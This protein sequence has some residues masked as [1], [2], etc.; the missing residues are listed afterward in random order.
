MADVML[1]SR[2]HQIW[3]L[4]T[5]TLCPVVHDAFRIRVLPWADLYGFD[6]RSAYQ[7]R[8]D[9]RMITAE[10]KDGTSVTCIGVCAMGSGYRLRMEGQ[11]DEACNGRF[12]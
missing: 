1:R 11:L 8:G 7:L 4:M 6:T 10:R 12:G 5:T 9:A 3:C 2:S